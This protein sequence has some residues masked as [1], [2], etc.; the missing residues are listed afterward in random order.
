MNDVRYDEVN[1]DRR[2]VRRAR[3]RDEVERID[4]IDQLADRLLNDRRYDDTPATEVWDIARER[5]DAEQSA[6][7]RAETAATQAMVADM[8]AEGLL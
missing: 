1:L 7:I 8:E 4:A 6:A 3:Y 2:D 5:I